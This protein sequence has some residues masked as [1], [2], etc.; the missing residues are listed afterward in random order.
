MITVSEGCTKRKRGK[1]KAQVTFTSST[2]SFSSDQTKHNIQMSTQTTKKTKKKRK[3]K[4]KT[5][6]KSQAESASHQVN[7]QSIQPIIEEKTSTT[8]TNNDNHNHSDMDM[9]AYMHDDAGYDDNEEKLDANDRSHAAPPLNRPFEP[10]TNIT[11]TDD[12]IARFDT[13]V[14]MNSILNNLKL[15]HEPSEYFRE[16]HDQIKRYPENAVIIR[17]EDKNALIIPDFNTKQNRLK[18]AEYRHCYKLDKWVCNCRAFLYQ[19]NRQFC[20]HILIAHLI[21]NDNPTNLPI[22]EYT[23][24]Q[25]ILSNED[26]SI[27]VVSAPKFGRKLAIYSVCTV[28]GRYA[29][30]HINKNCKNIVCNTHRNNKSCLHR[31]LVTD[32]VDPQL[33]QRLKESVN[34][35]MPDTVEWDDDIGFSHPSLLQEIETKCVSYKAIPV[36]KVYRTKYDNIPFQEDYYELKKDR[37][38]PTHLFP[39]GSNCM[40]GH[41]FQ[42]DD[43]R[44]IEKKALLFDIS[45]NY[46][47]EVYN[48]L[49]PN[50]CAIEPYDGLFDKIF[51]YNN[52]ILIYH[53]VFTQYQFL[54]HK[55]KIPMNTYI[56]SQISLYEGNNAESAFFTSPFFSKLLSIFRKLQGY[57]DKLFC[58]GCRDKNALPN[59]IGCDGTHLILPSKYIAGT[60]SPKDTTQLNDVLVR[61][62]SKMRSTRDVMIKEPELRKRYNKFL[63]DNYIRHYRNDDTTSKGVWKQKDTNR[64]FAEMVKNNYETLV[65][66]TKWIIR[67]IDELDL[68]LKHRMGDI[69]RG[70]SM[71][72]LLSHI[73]PW[74]IVTECLDYAIDKW[75]DI[76]TKIGR[77]QPAI[78]EV[79]ER[80]IKSGGV[81]P[82]EWIDLIQELARCARY[83]QILKE[84][85]RAEQK[86]VPAA[87]DLHQQIFSNYTESG[88]CYGYTV[89]HTR[90]AYNYEPREEQ[91]VGECNKYFHKIYGGMSNGIVIFKCMEHEEIMGFHVMKEPEGL[92]DYFSVILMMYPDESAPAIIVS[93]LACQLERYCMNREPKKFR[94]T[95]FLNDEI[96]AQGH[97][98]GP[99]YNVSYY[100]DSLASLFFLNDPSIEQTNRICKNLK[101]STMY[102]R[103]STFMNT[104]TNLLEIES[105]K[106]V[107]K[108]QT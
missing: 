78:Y 29:F 48:Y 49:C 42:K 74:P 70:C 89:H 7:N 106:S 99:L 17:N 63:I 105:R 43:L 30:V 100:K 37:E 97:K 65:K 102:M 12:E 23:S 96:H 56:C 39:S 93:D 73:I 67:N 45:S 86:D 60:V 10:I 92:N 5:K 104:V 9:D 40:C 50:C 11:P 82:K 75:E 108:R 88:T 33:K 71:N 4:T 3:H 61:I 53:D 68:R 54:R 18:Y 6:I 20:D 84:S 66:V 95:L 13:V 101:T 91:E 21:T 87:T 55:S 57:S 35:P 90:P 44:V 52:K 107:I 94:N 2:R 77:Y 28:N 34:K 46:Y 25:Q 83:A 15:D 19:S 69:L 76:K 79:H 98:C 58:R 59:I 24:L 8:G 103:L 41:E 16:F 81:P 72:T 85:I 1:K 64:L 62:A 31:K 32:N 36:P 47:V 38:I 14:A 51:N 26:G 27:C 22:K 80:F